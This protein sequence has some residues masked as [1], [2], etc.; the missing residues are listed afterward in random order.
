MLWHAFTDVKEVLFTVA[1]RNMR[2]RRAVKKIGAGTVTIICSATYPRIR[3][4]V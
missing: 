3:L 4:D 2:S 1:E